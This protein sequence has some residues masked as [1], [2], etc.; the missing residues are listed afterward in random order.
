MPRVGRERSAR[1]MYEE[2]FQPFSARH[3]TLYLCSQNTIDFHASN[4][5]LTDSGSIS[6]HHV[7]STAEIVNHNSLSRKPGWGERMAINRIDG[8]LYRADR[9]GF[10]PDLAIKMF[11]DLDTIFFD[12]YLKGRVNVRWCA[13][14]Y[15]HR[16]GVNGTTS[17]RQRG[18]ASIR[19]NANCIL[20]QKTTERGRLELMFAVLLHECCV[21]KISSAGCLLTCA[22]QK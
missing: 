14:N 21:S 9:H 4:H 13:E 15:F 3:G 7:E 8:G 5:L 19:L 2:A 1:E 12:G 11:K 20:L 17:P 22:F 6:T 18:Q 16:P 10:G